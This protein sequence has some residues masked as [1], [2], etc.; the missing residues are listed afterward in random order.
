MKCNA[1]LNNCGA[2]LDTDCKDHPIKNMAG[3][4]AI[5]NILRAGVEIGRQK[6]PE[7][8]C[9]SILKWKQDIEEELREAQEE[10]TAFLAQTGQSSV[11]RLFEEILDINV[12]VFRGLKYL[13]GMLAKEMEAR[14]EK[15]DAGD[16]YMRYDP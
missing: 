12:V 3:D 11:K 7:S 15:K 9:T 6:H 4:E 2:C 8:E 10:F 13:S 5:L 1:E 14:A 16:D